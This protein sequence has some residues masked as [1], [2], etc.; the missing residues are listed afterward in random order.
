MGLRVC[1]ALV[2]TLTLA[3]PGAPGKDLSLSWIVPVEFE[4]KLLEGK[5]GLFAALVPQRTV[6]GR[7][8]ESVVRRLQDL[9]TDHKLKVLCSAKGVA[10]DGALCEVAQGAAAGLPSRTFPFAGSGFSQPLTPQAV[11]LRWEL[12]RG[13]SLLV[14]PIVNSDGSVTL[15]YKLKLSN[16]GCPFSNAGQEALLVDMVVLQ[17]NLRIRTKEPCILVLPSSSQK[18]HSTYALVWHVA[19]GPRKVRID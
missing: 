5:P 4:L 12:L 8:A 18:S 19:T 14:H 16:G 13:S 1:A 17:G 9:V 6:S 7:K 3:A 10:A 11:E 2:A 15:S